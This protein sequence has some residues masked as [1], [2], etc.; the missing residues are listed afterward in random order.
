MCRLP[1]PYELFEQYEA[2]I[3]RQKRM[4]EKEEIEWEKADMEEKEHE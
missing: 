2:E 1:E 4:K 3:E